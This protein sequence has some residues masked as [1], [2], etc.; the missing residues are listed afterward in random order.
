MLQ[1]AR[2][3]MAAVVCA[4]I[5]I[6]TSGIF[7]PAHAVKAVDST[8][9]MGWNSYDCYSYGVT[10]AEVMANA[11]YMADSLKQFGWQYCVVDYIWWVPDEGAGYPP[12]QNSNWNFGNMDQY[13]RFLPDTTRFPSAKGG[14]GFKPLADSIHNLGLKF[15]IHLM[16]GVP[17]AA[18]HKNCP[19]FNSTYTCVQACD[20]TDPSTFTDYMYGANM[21][22]SAGQAYLNSILS[23]Y[24]GWGVDLIKVDDLL[25][26]STNFHLPE[27]I[28]YANAIASVSRP[29]LFSTS[30]G[31]TPVS[32]DTNL[33]KYA[34]QWRLVSDMWDSWSAI[35]NAFPTAET[36]RKILING[37]QISGPGHW[38]D[39]DMLPFGHLELYGPPVLTS[40]PHYSLT[41]LTRGQHKLVFFLWC[42]NNGPLI[43]GGN[44]PDNSTNPFYDSMTMN[45]AALFIDQHGTNGKVL[46]GYSPDSTPIWYSTHPTDTTTK[47]VGMFNL[48][49]K[50]ATMSV[51]LSSIGI[52][53]T[54]SVTDVW[55][56]NSLGKFSTTFSQSLTSENAGLYILGNGAT[57][58]TLPAPS[59][60]NSVSR[61]SEKNCMYTGNRFII[62]SSYSGKTVRVAVFNLSGKLLKSVITRDRSITLYK[63]QGHGEQVSI[64]KITEMP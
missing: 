5:M 17:K 21:K 3:L 50:T 15:G 32:E 25:T 45:S 42:I 11:H 7:V 55:T 49:G 14:A 20:T 38:L 19:V 40:T 8:P 1:V 63:N 39:V 28:G 23:L 43:W 2:R 41:T 60:K 59:R 18:Y 6:F 16:R 53:D 64:V 56:G 22:D 36:W 12:N 48:S 61:N 46:K 47:F 62:P 29:V 57:T 31:P 13:G 35:T 54:V 26:N 27:C 58:G 9:P 24:N 10:E 37:Q 51:N 52:N 34:N 4:I 44:L 30:P 33:I